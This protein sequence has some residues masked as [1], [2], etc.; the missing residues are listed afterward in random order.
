MVHLLNLTWTIYTQYD[1]FAEE[2][3]SKPNKIGVPCEI[4]PFWV[5]FNGP[6]ATAEPTGITFFFGV[7]TGDTG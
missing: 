7:E 5:S 4:S 3:S 6:K 2:P 1:I